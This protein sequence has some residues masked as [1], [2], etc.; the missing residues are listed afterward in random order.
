MK[1]GRKRGGTEGGKEREKSKR[2]SGEEKV[3][4]REEDVK[5]GRGG[6]KERMWT[7]PSSRVTSP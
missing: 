7:K 3:E 4:R 1:E 5:G 2:R 6:N